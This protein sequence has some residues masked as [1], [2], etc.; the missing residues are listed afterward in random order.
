MSGEP[1]W[2]LALYERER[3]DVLKVIEGTS[4]EAVAAARAFGEDGASIVYAFVVAPDVRKAAQV[5]KE[6]R[7]S[8][9]PSILQV[10]AD[11]IDATY[12]IRRA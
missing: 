5:M 1:R 6:F 2:Y 8:D 10:F 11:E 9:G 7:R 12:V 3:H 4:D